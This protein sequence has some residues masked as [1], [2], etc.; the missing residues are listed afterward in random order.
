M[1]L[2]VSQ[3]FKLVQKFSCE[4]KAPVEGI[5]FLIT[6]S[7][8]FL[9][10]WDFCLTLIM[11][12]DLIC[13]ELTALYLNLYNKV[14]C[15][16]MKSVGVSNV[17]GPAAAGIIAKKFQNRKMQEQSPQKPPLGP[18]DVKDFVSPSKSKTSTTAAN[19]SSLIS[20]K[21]S[22]QPPLLFVNKKSKSI[23]HINFSWILH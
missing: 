15:F 23:N 6:T 9:M 10:K 2:M 16:M 21:L 22:T 14:K 12:N 4:T 18:A 1:S 19:I 20:S 3:F 13:M 7:V 17:H 8:C 11:L 5:C